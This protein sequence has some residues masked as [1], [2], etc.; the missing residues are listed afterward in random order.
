MNFRDEKTLLGTGDAQVRTAASTHHQPAV[1]V[2]AY[3]FLWLAA[4]QLR[5][6][7]APPLSLLPPKWRHSKTGE[8]APALHTG[9]L[10]RALRCELCR[11]D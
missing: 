6:S 4:L 2:A 9:D 7:G 10:V 5:E 11:P 8:A 1:T 3:A